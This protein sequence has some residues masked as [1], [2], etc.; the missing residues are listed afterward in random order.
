MPAKPIAKIKS[1]NYK[2]AF[3][4]ATKRDTVEPL[5]TVRRMIVA[6]TWSSHSCNACAFGF[7]D[8]AFRRSTRS[9][10]NSTSD[11]F[12]FGKCIFIF[13]RHLLFFE[14]E[15]ISPYVVAGG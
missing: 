4:L 12:I 3:A 11:N 7:C 8:F 15:P 6:G 1:E 14:G 9:R 13:A 10:T 5:F 2:L